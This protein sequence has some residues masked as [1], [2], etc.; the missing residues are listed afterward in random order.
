MTGDLFIAR[1]ALL[2]ADEWYRYTLTRIW[3]AN[4]PRAL[5]VMLNPSTADGTEDDATV[6]RCMGYAR[7]WNCGGI[8][9]VNLFAWR[10]TD[11][12]E[13]PEC[14]DPIGPENDLWIRR[15]IND[16]VC[17]GAPIVC[18]WG[19]HGGLQ[20]RDRAVLALIA[21]CGGIPQCL[22]RNAG[23]HPAHP[24]Y[25]AADLFPVAYEGRP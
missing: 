13:L 16:A 24:L 25:L 22:Q 6:R 20:D 21:D 12:R 14:T 23:G 4:A 11:P 10:A 1:H 8:E 18:G 2:S 5:F 7:A 17:T 15:A 3:T 19:N 9:V